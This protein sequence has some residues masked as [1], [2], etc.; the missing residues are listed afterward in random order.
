MQQQAI[1]DRD[2]PEPKTGNLND[3][4]YWTFL[5]R[6]QDAFVER[7]ASGT[8]LFDTNAEG[9]WDAYLE[10]FA[11]E[12]RQFH[13]CNACKHFIQ[14]YGAL[15]TIAD[16]GTT[17]PLL[18]DQ[19]QATP[20]YAQA[21]AEVYRRVRRAKVTGVFLSSDKVLGHPVTGI[22]RHMAVELPRGCSAR[23]TEGL[24]TAGQ[25]M[26]EKREEHHMVM[27]ALG[28]FSP[29]TVGVAVQLLG[30]EALYR[31]EKVLGQAEWLAK[32]HGAR[33]AAE[34]SERKSNVVWLAVAKASA[35]FCHPRA[36]MI[37]TLL[38]DIA[39]GKAFEDVKRAF[40]AKMRPDQYQRPQAAPSAG[41][42]AQ[43]EKL[44]EKLGIA[45]SLERRFA[46]LE[47]IET[48]WNPAA[49]AAPA[50]G[51]VFA[52]LDPKRSQPPSS[53]HAQ[54]GRI[55]WEKFARD[56]LP[57]A[58]ELEVNVPAHGSFGAI[59]TAQ[60]LDAPPILQ[61]D[62]PEKRNPFSWYLYVNGSPASAWGLRMGWLKASAIA[63]EPHQWHGGDYPNQGAGAIFILPSAKDQREAGNALFPEILKSE[64]REV[65]ATI[66]AYSKTAK[67]GGREE[68]SAA[69][70]IMSKGGGEI[71]VRVSLDSGVRMGYLIDRWS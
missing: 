11:P 63:L 31:S 24:K 43:A 70:L 3:Q 36:S 4:D 19:A 17:T 15:V 68:A 48:I 13:N 14:R 41:N 45:R 12:V 29:Q 26:A 20:E 27:R 40:A 10:A 49:P 65:R 52:H 53:M 18:W 61:W 56:V 33:D 1:A 58:R 9:L 34:G 44:V 62:Q 32:L 51:G 35:G 54:A 16:D 50:A 37:G 57:T 42:I 7:V 47:E 38:E 5:A 25:A 60:H 2:I 66:E 30:A 55:T 8:P 69:G 64:L 28:E 71:E 23:Y 21:F 67:I 22:W 39:A 46:R 59:L 6:I